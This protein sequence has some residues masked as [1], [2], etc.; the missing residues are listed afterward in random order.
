MWNY[1]ELI[2][3]SMWNSSSHS[4]IKSCFVESCGIMWNKFIAQFLT[5][6]FVSSGAYAVVGVPCH[7]QHVYYHVSMV[8]LEGLAWLQ[9]KQE[10]AGGSWTCVCM[11]RPKAGFLQVLHT[12]EGRRFPQEEDEP[13][14]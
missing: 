14:L 12:G 4:G 2:S 7:Q 13:I 1:G 6:V 3:V 11:V 10:R 8:F 9:R 5:T